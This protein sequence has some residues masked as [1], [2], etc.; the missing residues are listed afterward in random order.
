MRLAPLLGAVGLALAAVPAG[1]ADGQARTGFR[2]PVTIDWTTRVERTAEG[3]H[4]MGN[5]DAPLKLVEYGSITCSHCADFDAEAGQTIR[6]HVRS[7]R[8]SFEYRPYLIF[9]SDP[10]IFLLLNCQPPERF[11]DTVHTLYRTQANWVA[12]LESK[13]AQI[14][15][16]IQGGS[17]P[18][19]I[20]A[21]VRATGTDSL[22]RQ[23]GLTDRQIATCL[24]DSA[25][26][27]R[28]SEINRQG[29]ALGVQGTPTFFLNGR[30]LE[31]ARWSDLDAALRQP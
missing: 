11:F 12:S 3:G 8:L 10:G 25:G 28:L 2:P 16:E 14:E 22:F 30:E 29:A 23:N 5:P 19:A 4:R 13:Q 6:D 7:G 15:A 1:A 9:P 17:F 27:Q 31:L 24:A 21:I 26:L 18:A 20:P